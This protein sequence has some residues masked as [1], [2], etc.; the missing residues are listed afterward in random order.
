LYE[1]DEKYSI[2]KVELR[3]LNIYKFNA[4]SKYQDFSHEIIQSKPD[5]SDY[6]YR[7]AHLTIRSVSTQ[8]ELESIE[9]RL[10]QDE[11][12]FQEDKKIL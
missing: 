11:L 5:D 9:D 7:A 12:V 1:V 3:T 8:D 6:K 10:L 4:Y 2:F